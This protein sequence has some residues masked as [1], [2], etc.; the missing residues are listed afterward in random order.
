M[1]DNTP[2]KQKLFL[3]KKEIDEELEAKL[4]FMLRKRGYITFVDHLVPPEVSWENFRY[5]RKRLEGLNKRNT[6]PS[7][8]G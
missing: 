7:S 5:Y 1:L 3:G 4:P 8:Q 2:L 6:G